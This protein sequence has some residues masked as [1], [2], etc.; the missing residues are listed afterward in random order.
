MR[1]DLS[2]LSEAAPL[3]ALEAAAEKRISALE[4]SLT[5]SPALR[6]HTYNVQQGG[7]AAIPRFSKTCGASAAGSS[8]PKLVICVHF[9]KTG[10]LCCTQAVSELLSQHVLQNYDKFVAG[11]DVVGKVEE[12]LI[13][14]YQ[15]AKV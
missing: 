5:R 9:V 14:A 13:A 1:F 15:T 8:T 4:V 7:L 3:S 12:D 6:G 10:L 2:K 11:I